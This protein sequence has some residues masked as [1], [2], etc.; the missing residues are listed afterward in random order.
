MG[1]GSGP[2]WLVLL[3]VLLVILS[4]SLAPTTT[5]HSPLTSFLLPPAAASPQSNY[6]ACVLRTELQVFAST[7]RCHFHIPNPPPEAP[8]S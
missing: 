1:H 4:H 6:A 7:S 8:P 5:H 2:P 3:L